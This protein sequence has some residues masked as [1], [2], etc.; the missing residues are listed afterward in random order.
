M[1][2]VYSLFKTTSLTIMFFAATVRH[3]F[4]IMK[5]DHVIC[6]DEFW[7]NYNDTLKSAES[8]KKFISFGNSPKSGIKFNDLI[9]KNVDVDSFEPATV[10]GQD[11]TAIILHSSGTTGNPKGV[12][13]T[14]LNAIITSDPELW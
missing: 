12:K 5:P 13:L 14:H 6:S 8:I 3:L 1:C 4:N 7:T 2:L 11:D 10:R 9:S